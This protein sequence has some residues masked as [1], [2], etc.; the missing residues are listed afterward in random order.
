MALSAEERAEQFKKQDLRTINEITEKCLFLDLKDRDDID[1]DAEVL[2]D[3]S[4]KVLN[5]FRNKPAGFKYEMTDRGNSMIPTKMQESITNYLNQGIQAEQSRIAPTASMGSGH[6]KQLDEMKPEI[7]DFFDKVT[8]IRDGIESVE[9]NPDIPEDQ[10]RVFAMSIADDLKEGIAKDGNLK[11]KTI[12]NV[13]RDVGRKLEM[14][15]EMSKLKMDT[16]PKPSQ[17]TEAMEQKK[18]EKNRLGMGNL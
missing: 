2:N 13:D 11:M 10:K 3:D 17:D 15:N 1:L 16:E 12:N 7:Q 14:F 6:Q 4:R 9:N 8:R 5:N 18:K